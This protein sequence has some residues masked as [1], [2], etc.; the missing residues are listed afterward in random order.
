HPGKVYALPQSPQ[1]LKQLLMIASTD[2]YFQIAKCFRDEDLRADRQ[3]EFTQIDIETSF[4]TPLYIKKIVEKI[5]IDL[6]KLPAGYSLPVMSY[7]QVMEKYGSDKPDLRYGLEQYN[8]T[9]LFA[10][11]AFATF[12][13]VAQNRGLVK[14][15]FVSNKVGSLTRKMIDQ[16]KD[17][18]APFG[19]K[20]VAWFK[21]ENGAVSGGI[22]KFITDDILSTLYRMANENNKSDG[23]WLFIADNNHDIAHNS[24]DALRRFLGEN[25]KLIG[26]EDKF[27]WVEKFP[28]FEWNGEDKRFYAK[29]HPFTSVAQESMDDFLSGDHA[30]LVNCKAE[31]YD[32]VCNGYEIGG[33]SIR[34]HNQKVQD[35]MFQLLGMSESEIRGQFGFF[36]DALKYGV[37]PHGGL[38]LGL[39]RLMMILARTNNIKDVIAFPKTTSA[40]DLM[41]D[42]PSVPA[43]AQLNEL[44]LRWK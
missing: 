20:G 9:S 1:T 16:F 34:I 5:L 10:N 4:P 31:A 19:G 28:L 30:R 12:A 42:A 33:G 23:V 39:D 14:A 7:D 41:A 11:S 22:A 25:L 27:L 44:K 17:V 8:V 35:K 24:S 40:A 3:P 38:A 2:K 29:H 18:V 6:F 21:M 15:M 36:I 13:D 43:E 32:V 26:S 37:P